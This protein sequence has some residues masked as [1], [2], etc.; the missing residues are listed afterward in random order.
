MNFEQLNIVV[1]DVEA[2]VTFYRQLGIDAEKTLDEWMPHHRSVS[3]AGG[4][5]VD[6]DSVAFARWWGGI[7]APCVVVGVRM[8][9][10]D[11]VDTRYAAL[12]DAGSE[13]LRPPFDAFWGA[14]FAVVRDPAGNA[15]ALTSPLDP[16]RQGPPPDPATF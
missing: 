1:D 4:L 2:A 14:R 13:G 7:N 11:E 8:P 6:I 9:S 3:S 15:I 16:D 12:V 10:R 5:D